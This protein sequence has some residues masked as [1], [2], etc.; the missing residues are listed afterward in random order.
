M[1]EAERGTGRP[2][3]EVRE[4]PAPERPR[5]R[6][7]RYG[8][9]TLGD[10]E[11]LAILLG[12]GLKGRGVMEVARGMID[13]WGVAGLL[14]AG[15]HE[16]KRTPGLGDAKA[17]TIAAGVELGARAARQ[18]IGRGESISK[19][20][21]IWALYGRQ[22]SAL[23]HEEVRVV[24]L[25]RQNRVM[26]DPTLYRGTA[27]GASVRIAEMLREVIV[28]QGAGMI[29]MHNHPSGDPTPSG[30]DIE[31]TQALESAAK[32][33]DVELLDHVILGAGE[34][35]PWTSMRTAGYLGQ[36]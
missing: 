35:Q 5:E 22:M 1:S 4:L 2:G 9:E 34:G 6:L 15:P 3:R 28:R 27:H 32:L 30:A 16:L 18:S 12:T 8:A 25:N 23:P 29:V 20:Q 33:M 26:G 36:D 14:R 31:M 7:L 13:D 21:Q 17:C 19:P 11:L 24:V 10:A